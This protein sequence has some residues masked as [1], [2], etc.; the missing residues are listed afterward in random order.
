MADGVNRV[1]MS[2]DLGSFS[3]GKKVS[4]FAGGDTPAEVHDRLSGL[5]GSHV[6]DELLGKI[7]EASGD[8]FANAVNNLQQGGLVGGGT[9]AP[10]RSDGPVC[11]HGP[12]VYKNGQ[13]AK[14]PWS[15]WMCSLPKGTMGAC[16]PEWVK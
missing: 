8:S 6:V 16:P 15:A 5:L 12:R 14:G 4:V 2:V 1:W 9:A 10:A 11:Q 7:V 13:S 3:L